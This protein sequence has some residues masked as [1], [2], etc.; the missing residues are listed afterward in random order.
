[1]R[2]RNACPRRTAYQLLG[3]DHLAGTCLVRKGLNYRY[4]SEGSLRV[5]AGRSGCQ[6]TEACGLSVS[7]IINST[8]R[9]QAGGGGDARR[10]H[11]ETAGFMATATKSL[12]G[13]G[14]G[15][16]SLEER[17]GRN[18]FYNDRSGSDVAFRR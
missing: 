17:V 9:L 13:T 5:P 14:D 8:P 11:A 1:M 15:G 4:P 16:G 7:E 18:K 2:E 3:V 12:Y 10:H 6:S